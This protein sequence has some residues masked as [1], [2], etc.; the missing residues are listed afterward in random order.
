MTV[1][2]AQD[3]EGNQQSAKKAQSKTDI[4]NPEG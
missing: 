1:M 2:S 3:T 4:G